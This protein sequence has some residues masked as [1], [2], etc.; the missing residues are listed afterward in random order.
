MMNFGLMFPTNIMMMMMMIRIIT[1]NIKSHNVFS[2]LGMHGDFLSGSY[3][4]D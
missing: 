4:F 1:D 2:W 3:Y